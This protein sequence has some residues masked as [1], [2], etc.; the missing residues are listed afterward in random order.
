MP[1]K[2]RNDEDDDQEKKNNTNNHFFYGAEF[3]IQ[4]LSCLFQ[5]KRQI[6]MSRCCGRKVQKHPIHFIIIQ[7]KYF[8]TATLLQN[9][10]IIQL[11]FYMSI[12]SISKRMIARY[13]E[14]KYERKQS[15][16]STFAMPNTMKINVFWKWYIFI[17][18]R[19]HICQSATTETVRESKD[20]FL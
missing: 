10:S 7:M 15:F 17:F 5:F 19:L 14:K 12:Q 2:R 9:R 16:F 6:L 20:I 13:E 1:K 4:N 8:R 11:F 18:F 3:L